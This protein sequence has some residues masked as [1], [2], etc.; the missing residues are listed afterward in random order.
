MTNKIPSLIVAGYAF[1]IVLVI[2]LGVIAMTGLEHLNSAIKDLQTHPF[3]VSDAAL[4]M[5]GDLFSTRNSVLR[6]IVIRGRGENMSELIRHIENADR[7]LLADLTILKNNFSGDPARLGELERQLDDLKKLHEEIIRLELS[8]NHNQAKNFIGTRGAVTFNAIVSQLDSLVAFARNDAKSR[9]KEADREVAHQIY[10]IK[11]FLLG[12]LAVIGATMM[13]VTSRIR[14]VLL[15]RD[16]AMNELRESEQ[17]FRDMLDHAPI[18]T[19]MAR[20]SDG[21]IVQANRAMCKLLGYSEDELREMTIRDITHPDDLGTSIVYWKELI[22]G[23]SKAVQIR[24]RFM[25]KNGQA[26]LVNASISVYRNE[27]GT[28]YFIAQVEDVEERKRFEVQL[29]ESEEK[30]RMLFESA[31][32][33]MLILSMTGQIVDIN[34]IGH[35]Q[36][37]YAKEEMIGQHIADFDSPEF[38]DRVPE[39]MARIK[40]E[41]QATFESA[42]MHRN[43]TVIPVEISSRMI[44]LGGVKMIYSV[45]RNISERKKAER[46]LRD[47][48]AKYRAIIETSADGFWVVDME[49]RLLEVNDAYVRLS[50][51]SHEELLNMRVPDLEALEQPEQTAAHIQKVLQDGHD[52]FETYH[53]T[54]DG[55][56]VPVEIVVGSWPSVSS[57]LFGFIVDISARKKAEQALRDSE[58]Q[59]RAIIETSL[60]G[61]WIVDMEGRLLEVNDTYVQLS[62]YSREELLNM[63]I[64][65]LEAVERPEET[66][67][68]IQKVLREGQDRFESRH[69]TKDGRLIP[70]EIAASFWPVLSGRLFVF[71]TDISQRIKDIEHIGLLA[72]AFETGVEAM[73]ITDADNCIT[74]VNHAFTQLTGYALEEVQGKNPHILSSGEQSPEF[75]QAMWQ[76]LLRDDHWHGEIVDRRKDGSTYPKWLSI[77]LVR[78]ETGEIVNHIA[79][80]TDITEQKRAESEIRKLAYYDSLTGL[81]NRFSLLVQLEQELAKAHRNQTLLA[82]MF[83]DLDRFKDIND[84][85]GHHVGDGLLIQV[86][87]RL[88][89]VMR[90]SDL[91]ARHGGDE[92][93]LLLSD[94]HHADEAALVANKI[95]SHIA[96]PYEVE[97]HRLYTSPSI[98]ISIYPEDGDDVGVL[99]QNAD[100][101][102]YHAKSNGGNN[103][104]FFDPDMNNKASE[105]M[106]TENSLRLA[107]E[108]DEFELYYQPQLALDGRVIAAEAL[109][110]W[111]HPE[112]GL[113]LPDSFIHISEETGLIVPIG[114]WVLETACRQLR[115]WT[116]QGLALERVSVNVS[117]Q[118]FLQESFVE[119][120]NRSISKAGI[121]PEQIELE[122]T[123]NAAMDNSEEVIN[124]M[125]SLRTSGV[126]LAIDDFGTGYSSLSYLRIFPI[127]QLKIDRSFIQDLEADPADLAITVSTIELSHKLGIEVVAEGI[128]S[129]WQ[130]Q[131]LLHHG[132]DL[133]QGYLYSKPLPAD[134]FVKFLI[135]KS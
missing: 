48:E 7:D 104:Y 2:G 22:D 87:N 83:I 110:R 41:G 6:L 95:I 43:G 5:K 8:G 129:E 106:K 4:D 30:F 97:G 29:R 85:L 70:V 26:I 128:D 123:E 17:R 60:D 16:Q 116:D 94:I 117:A 35:E 75:Y 105:R 32:D 31:S 51:Y 71:V 27:E 99:M 62:G 57:R 86:A 66:A 100:L 12:F 77:S 120:V 113:L 74:E 9:I 24:K 15:R 49:G 59:Y 53:R 92:F 126:R 91:V 118:E 69:R 124:V 54:K 34:R 28:Q 1:A 52:R 107:V 81:F 40:H 37:G 33:C 88:R 23:R 96:Q 130:S 25:H 114:R 93:V 3:A 111:N 46:A 79:S 39:R 65:D 63:R 11:L 73:L 102:M 36:L 72:K 64:P 101:A 55:R 135:A 20:A 10:N 112:R 133:R 132:C 109:I 13:G 76:T 45:I 98:G 82:L 21:H 127:D 119:F 14:Y 18:G 78:N 38:A 67:A 44:T 58:A 89:G 108:R 115:Q 61:F 125:N 134:D 42:H 47:S 80:F 90:E 131:V 50:G 103:F 56:I 68:H 122:V 19:S 84:T 121:R